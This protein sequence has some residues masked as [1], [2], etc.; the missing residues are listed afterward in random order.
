MP[1]AIVAG[2]SYP[3]KAALAIPEPANRPICRIIATGQRRFISAI[4]LPLSP[5]TLSRPNWKVYNLTWIKMGVRPPPFYAETL[6]WNPFR[7]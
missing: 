7:P 5:L 4:A 6:V 2:A 3:V 1:K